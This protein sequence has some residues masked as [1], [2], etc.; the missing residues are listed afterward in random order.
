M[1]IPSK[2]IHRINPPY[3]QLK[4]IKLKFD[5]PTSFFAYLR[6]SREIEEDY[7]KDHLNDEIDKKIFQFCKL[8]SNKAVCKIDEAIVFK[9]CLEQYKLLTQNSIIHKISLNFFPR[10]EVKEIRRRESES[11][12]KAFPI[13]FSIYV[14]SSTEIGNSFFPKDF[15]IEVDEAIIGRINSIKTE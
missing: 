9:E 12:L 6:Y 1:P 14:F 4:V 3:S 8:F 5:Y 7:Q 11:K 2:E 13:D 15:F 10:L